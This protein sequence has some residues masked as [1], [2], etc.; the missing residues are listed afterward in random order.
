MHGLY[1]V[2]QAAFAVLR[3][4]VD[5]ALEVVD[6]GQQA[7]DQLLR[8]AR[9]LDLALLGGAAAIRVPL[10]VQAQVL[11]LPIL[12]LRLG[13]SHLLVSRGAGVFDD[14]GLDRL[15]LRRRFRGGSVGRGGFLAAARVGGPGLRL[16]FRI[17]RT[18][19]FD[20]NAL[21]CALSRALGRGLVGLGHSDYFPSFLSSSSTTS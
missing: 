13:L 8:R 9:L 20:G 7:G 18:V 21:A 4:V 15:A 17:R 12:G 14:L 1:A 10:G 3:R 2:E 19:V 16:G 11:V 5:G 6:D